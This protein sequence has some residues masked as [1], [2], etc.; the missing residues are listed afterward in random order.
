MKS[1]LERVGR[2][3]L[4]RIAMRP[5]KPLIFGQVE[6]TPFIGTPGNPVSLFVTF[7]LFALP[8]IRRRQGQR[9]DL[10][11]AA[12]PVRAGFDWTRPDRRTEFHRAR[13]RQGHDGRPELEIFPSR[14]SA[15]L[16]SVAWADGLIEI[17]AQRVIHSGDLVDFIPFAGLLS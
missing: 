8:A 13:L 15:V 2:V 12:Y 6:E 7:C 16:S 4:W 1:A 11:P 9:G 10:R 3:T 17:P 14:S 5:G